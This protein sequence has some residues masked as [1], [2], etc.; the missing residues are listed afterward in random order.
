MAYT[1]GGGANNSISLANLNAWCDAHFGRVRG[2]APETDSRDRPYDVP[3]LVMDSRDA[4]RDFEW[5]RE[6]QLDAIL[7]EISLHAEQHP[8]WLEMSGV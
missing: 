5:K 1:V 6:V 7:E 4:E 8:N 2:R 3:W